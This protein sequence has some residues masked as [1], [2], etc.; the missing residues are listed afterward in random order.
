M[1]RFLRLLPFALVLGLLA[2]GTPQERCIWRATQELEAVESLLAEVEGNLARGYA[3][4]DYQET[5]MRWVRCVV[6]VPAPPPGPPGSAPPPPPQTRESLCFEPFT[7]TLQRRVAIDPAAE[8]RKR[9]GLIAQRAELRRKAEAEIAQC[10][11][12]YPE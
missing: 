4:E 2:C 3:W 1:H 11:V 12:L 7:V 6:P 10:R 8:R 5:Q 9:D